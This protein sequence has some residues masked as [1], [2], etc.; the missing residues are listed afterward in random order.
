MNIQIRH[1]PPDLHEALKMKAVE[2]R[3]TLSDY[4][5]SELERLARRPALDEVTARIRARRPVKAPVVE[6]LRAERG[7]RR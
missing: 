7:A 2:A 4:L 1:V 3:M 6:A 5:L